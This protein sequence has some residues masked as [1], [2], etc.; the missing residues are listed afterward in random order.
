MLD[1]RQASRVHTNKKVDLKLWEPLLQRLQTFK[2]Q[3]KTG[4]KADDSISKILALEEEIVENLT[5][6]IKLLEILQNFFL[7]CLVD[8]NLDNLIRQSFVRIIEPRS[9]LDN[10]IRFT[11]GLTHAVNIDVWL[12]NIEDIANIYI[13]VRG[14]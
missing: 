6:E 5:E 11:S 9:N 8:L 14:S 12:D 7:T 10:P 3:V 2:D 13:K 4:N 1:L